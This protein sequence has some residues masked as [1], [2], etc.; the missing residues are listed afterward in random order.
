MSDLENLQALKRM[1][2]KKDEAELDKN[3]ELE[4]RFLAAAATVCA[5]S[6][7]TGI[8]DYEPTKMIA[9]LSQPPVLLQQIMGGEWRSMDVTDF[10]NLAYTVCKKVQKSQT[11]IDWGKK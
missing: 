6:N 8:Q 5:G 1:L 4:Q 9:F 7:A 11:L 3:R 2:E 10:G